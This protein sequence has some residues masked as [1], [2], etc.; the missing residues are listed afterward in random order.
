MTFTQSGQQRLL[1]PTQ[2]PPV[3]R[4]ELPT[5]YDLPSE[6]PEELGLP[7]SYHDL[8]PELLSETLRLQDYPDGQYFTGSD[9]NIYYDLENRLWHKRPD[10]F[11]VVGVPFLHD[12]GDL[13]LSYV[14]WQEAANPFVIVELISPGTEDEDF[15]RTTT[16]PDSPPTKWTVYEQILQVPY[17]V[18]FNRYIDELRVFK[19]QAGQYQ[20]LALPDHRLWIPE[21][22]IGLG[23]WQGTYRPGTY[24]E[25]ERV[26]LRWYDADDQW[27]LTTTELE[28]QRADAERQRADSEQQRAISSE[29]ELATLKAKLRD[30]GIDLDNV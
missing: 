7:D 1:N 28:R 10:W 20:E 16:E 3:P 11:L 25:T 15:G 2:P 17:Y 5:M 8:Q 26:W 4:H 29:A 18:V 13:R 23:L 19:W 12:S 14:T 9:F 6:F 30:R 27:L 22:K 21:L 24:R